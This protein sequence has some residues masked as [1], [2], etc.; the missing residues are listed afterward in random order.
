MWIVKSLDPWDLLQPNTFAVP[1]VVC[2]SQST[3]PGEGCRSGRP[4]NSEPSLLSFPGAE[5]TGAASTS[6]SSSYYQ[7]SGSLWSPHCL[8]ACRCLSQQ[9]WGCKQ[10]YSA[11]K[12]NFHL[13]CFQDKILLIH[14]PPSLESFFLRQCVSQASLVLTVV[15]PYWP[16]TIDNFLPCPPQPPI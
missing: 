5:I 4:S 7:R 1:E 13:A 10:Q 15:K 8:Q 16:P 2:L 9:C 11:F 6:S 3:Y 12:C 14:T